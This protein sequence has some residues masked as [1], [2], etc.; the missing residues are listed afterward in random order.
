MLLG[1]HWILDDFFWSLILLINDFYETTQ[2]SLRSLVFELRGESAVWLMLTEPLDLGDKFPFRLPLFPGKTMSLHDLDWVMHLIDAPELLCSKSS[3]SK[4]WTADER[5]WRRADEPLDSSLNLRASPVVSQPSSS[6]SR[7]SWQDLAWLISVMTISTEGMHGLLTTKSSLRK[8]V[9]ARMSLP[10]SDSLPDN[11][12]EPSSLTTEHFLCKGSVTTAGSSSRMSPSP[13]CPVFSRD[14][15]SSSSWSNWALRDL[16]SKGGLP[17]E[18][19]LETP[20]FL[21]GR[22]WLFLAWGIFALDMTSWALAMLLLGM[23]WMSFII[24]SFIIL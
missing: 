24:L 9:W 4:L 22:A 1:F 16:S 21:P 12:Q 2:Q 8:R 3:V 6:L 7:R 5:L 23:P 11:S 10:V 18:G 17:M 13:E 14:W 15:T 19:G 20:R